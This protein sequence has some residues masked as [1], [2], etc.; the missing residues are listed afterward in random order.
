ML[1][2]IPATTQHSIGTLLEF[3]AIPLA[4]ACLSLRASLYDYVAWCKEEYNRRSYE[5][6]RY[7]EEGKW[8]A[9]VIFGEYGNF[10]EWFFRGGRFSNSLGD[11][12]RGEFERRRTDADSDSYS[13]V[14]SSPPPLQP[15][16]PTDTIIDVVSSSPPTSPAPSSNPCLAY[17]VHEIQFDSSPESDYQRW[18][19]D[20]D[21]EL[22]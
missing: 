7:H 10:P 5:W 17:Y 2:L 19:T 20:E 11:A 8:N 21:R 14:V 9:V 18:I 3:A 13:P 4:M 15:A 1:T 16:S 22:N 12:F 6:P